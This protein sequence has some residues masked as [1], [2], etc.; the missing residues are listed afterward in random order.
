MF[1]NG[2]YRPNNS[3]A[4]NDANG[5]LW[6][7]RRD[8]WLAKL[9]ALPP[10][11]S[12]AAKDGVIVG[13]ARNDSLASCAGTLQRGGLS[14]EALLAALRAENAARCSPP[15]SDDEVRKIAKSVSRYA[16]G[17]EGDRGDEAEKLVNLVLH[18]HFTDGKHLL[19]GAD[20]QFWHYTGKMWTVAQDKWIEGRT[21]GE[22]RVVF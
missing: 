6:T 2:S 7:F 8:K 14:S 4:T 22:I 19:F 5:H 3:R 18:R 20:G 9:A 15:L 16:P 21:C 13:G 1:R 17:S 11:E 12:D 10:P